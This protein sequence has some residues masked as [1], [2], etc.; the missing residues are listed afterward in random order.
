MVGTSGTVTTLA[1]VLLDL[2]RYD[3]ARVDGV[4]LS[5]ADIGAVS[6]RLAGLDCAGRAA[7]PCIGPER[8][9]LVVAGCAVLEA[10]CT[11]WPVGR[12]RVADRGLRDGML[13]G[14]MRANGAGR[15]QR[16]TV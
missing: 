5:F 12:L 11:A 10:I 14:L 16:E 4:S 13:H 1:G 9:D 7:Y 8:A 2:P 15:P 6:R 3:R